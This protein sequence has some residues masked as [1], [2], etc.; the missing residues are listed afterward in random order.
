VNHKKKIKLITLLFGTMFLVGCAYFRQPPSFVHTPREK[1]Q[2]ELQQIKTWTLTGSLSITH[3]KK[4][5]IARF[6]WT[7][8]QNDYTINISG[9]LNISSIRIVGNSDNIELWRTNKKC[10]KAKTPEQL[11]LDQLGWQLPIS[12]IRYWILALPTPAA[13]I[14]SIH[15][16]QYGHIIDL[17]QNGWQ[18][19]YSEFQTQVE[20]NF[21]LPKIVELKN[22]EI[23]IKLKITEHNLNTLYYSPIFRP[24]EET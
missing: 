6:K 11:M 3:N 15:F 18:I 12:N 7:Q 19:K 13:K 10:I 17:E 20:K 21:D 8:N 9:P 4:R 2:A 24:L 5:D 16:D 23:A 1:R 22:K 14:D